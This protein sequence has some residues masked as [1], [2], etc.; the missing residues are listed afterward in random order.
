M[1]TFTKL[2]TAA[3]VAATI[4][5]AS[6]VKAQ[7]SMSMPM[8]NGMAFK[9]GVGVSGGIFSKQSQFKNAYGADLRLQYDL[10]KSVAITASGGYTKL[11]GRDN[12]ADVDFIPVIGGV[13]VF[14]IQRF[15]LQGNA[16][17]G[18]A[19]QTG[20]KTN[21]IYGGGVGYEW[22]NGLEL[23][24]RYEGYTNDSASSTYFSKMEQYALRLG[25]NFKL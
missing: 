23:G 9:V 2:F 6:N 10:T 24:A 5:T 15:Y 21:F 7:E 14:A 16:G 13:K 8:D 19:I 25:Y 17:A 20:A 22:K 11:L 4:F 18:F 12:S 3:A 1:K